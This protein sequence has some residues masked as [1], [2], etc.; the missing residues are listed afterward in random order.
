MS[1]YQYFVAGGL[2]ALLLGSWLCGFIF[3]R[4]FRDR[5]HA[6][7]LAA[8]QPDL[9]TMSQPNSDALPLSGKARWRKQAEETGDIVLQ[10]LVFWWRALEWLFVV[11]IVLS[12]L[13]SFR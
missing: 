5:H 6:R 1:A 8:G 2:A 3:F 11:G 12:I 9:S 10:R 13:W 7:W 4:R